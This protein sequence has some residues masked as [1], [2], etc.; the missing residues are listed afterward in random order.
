MASG[1]ALA[2]GR[3][4]LAFGFVGITPNG[5]AV[6]AWT[7]DPA[8]PVPQWQRLILAAN[9]GGMVHAAE[10]YDVAN[11]RMLA[12]GGILEG[13]LDGRLW[14]LDLASPV[15][16]WS[17]VQ[18]A[19][20]SRPGPRRG[21]RFVY[22]PNGGN[23]RLLMFGG[24]KGSLATSI[25]DEL[26]E[27]SL[28][29]GLESWNQLFLGG[30]PPALADASVVY[31][32]ASNAAFFHGGQLASGGYVNSTWRL[33][34]G[35]S[36]A[37][38]L[39]SPAGAPPARFAHSAVF[40]P[41]GDRMII[42]GGYRGSTAGSAEIYQYNFGLNSW[43]PLSVGVLAPTARY[44]HSA[45][46]D[47]TPGQERMIILGGYSSHALSDSWQLDLRAGFPTTFSVLPG[48]VAQP[49]PRWGHCAVFDTASMRIVVAGGYV[50]G[51][52]VATQA[53]GRTVE[54]WFFGR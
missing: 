30:G 1:V 31:H 16:A 24:W 17:E 13:V 43:A 12:F 36:P 20:A 28:T 39:L 42:F 52:M 25:C 44:Y 27:L 40:D 23:P 26:W 5:G 21:A 10:A 47:P 48:T 49:Q 50:D 53:L 9:P 18:P 41:I 54:T 3:F 32:P 35:A 45:V 46:F 34:L 11:N 15:A 14:Q 8:A 2:S 33:T 51:E 6:D 7:V 19:T 38:A 29:P 37:W 22:D 4:F